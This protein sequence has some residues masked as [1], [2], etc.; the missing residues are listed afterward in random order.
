MGYIFS[1][2]SGIQGD[3]GPRLASVKLLNPQHNNPEGMQCII[4][5][6]LK[7]QGTAG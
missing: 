5:Q 1:Q 3:Y 7:C 2:N 6:N 4:Y